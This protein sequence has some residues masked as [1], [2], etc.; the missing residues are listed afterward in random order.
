MRIGR[1]TGSTPFLTWAMTG[2]VIFLKTLTELGAC[3]VI[4]SQEVK[5]ALA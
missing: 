3:L 5:Q 1:V 2:H 4:T